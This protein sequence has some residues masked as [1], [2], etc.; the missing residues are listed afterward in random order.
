MLNKKKIIISTLITLFPILVGLIFWNRL[1]DTVPIHW[2][3]NGEI[4]GWASKTVAILTLPIFLSILNA[5]CILITHRDNKN[6]EQNKKLLMLTYWIIPVLSIIISG[7]I[8]CTAFGIALN[9]IKILPVALGIIF[10]FIGNYM[11]K[12]RYNHTI[13]IRIPTTLKSKENWD[14]THYFAGK[15]WVVGSVI[16]ILSTLLP[17]NVIMPVVLPVVI[18]MALVPTIYSLIIAKK[19]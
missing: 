4:D 13:G 1:P 19:K 18:I 2:N 12:C 11:P 8:Y 17:Y 5:F 10:F 9:S 3:I 14:K 16:I 15:I 6:R 7:L